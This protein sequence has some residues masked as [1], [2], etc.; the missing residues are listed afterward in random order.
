[1]RGRRH[2]D[3]HS[4]E[5]TSWGECVEESGR[6]DGRYVNFA[7][8]CFP[9]IVDVDVGRGGTAVR[10]SDSQSR[11]PGFESS[12]RCRFEVWTIS[13]TP[14]VSVQSAVDDYLALDDYL[15]VDSSLSCR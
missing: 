15:A 7:M 1:M 11:E 13:F 2:G 9:T 6:G 10:T 4:Q 3:G 5:Y 12:F 8:R 14:I